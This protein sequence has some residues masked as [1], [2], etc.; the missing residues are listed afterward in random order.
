AGLEISNLYA[1]FAALI[2]N[3]L[4][5]GGELVA[6]TPRSFCNGVYF[7]PFRQQLLNAV[8]LQRLH[9]FES[10]EAAFKA[11]DV[12]QENVIMHA[13]KGRSNPKRVTLST[14]SGSPG[15]SVNV[16]EV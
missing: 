6:I 11:D 14:S 10:R 8:A 12:L 9:V 16:R 13:I 5:R 1:A 4:E 3:L 7:R 15:E 2:I